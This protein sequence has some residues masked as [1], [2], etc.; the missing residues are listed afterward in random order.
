MAKLASVKIT[1]ED[2]N[3]RTEMV[4]GETC[5][6]AVT[7]QGKIIVIPENVNLFKPENAF[8]QTNIQVDACGMVETINFVER[9][10]GID[11]YFGNDLLTSFREASSMLVEMFGNRNNI[12]INSVENL[13][14]GLSCVKSEYFFVTL[15]SGVKNMLNS[16]RK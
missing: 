12:G 6:V 14:G 7:E 10:S 1:V 11:L 9:E 16:K 13:L 5:I 15:A 4:I 3:T 2:S 8:E